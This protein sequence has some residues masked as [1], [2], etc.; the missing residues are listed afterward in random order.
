[1]HSSSTPR[2]WEVA[3]AE[4]KFKPLL[5]TI[6]D[7]ESMARAYLPLLCTSTTGIKLWHVLCLMTIQ[8]HLVGE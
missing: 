5:K 6:I 2:M 3:E 1:M 7:V 4:T 8:L